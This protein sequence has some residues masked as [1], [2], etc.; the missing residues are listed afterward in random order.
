ME[1]EKSKKK[2][3]I[4]SAINLR[5]GG[6]LSI[7]HDCL[8]YLD[9]ALTNSYKVVALIHSNS[10]APKT[11]NIHYI[12]FPK[13]ASC[14]LFR[15]YYEY[16]YFYRLSKDLNPYVWLSLHDTSPR[17]NT[18]IQAVYCH[19][20]SPFYKITKKDFFLDK[21]FALQSLLYKFIYLINIKKNNYVIVQQ[22]WIKK[23]F[24]KAFK[25][26]NIIVAKPDTNLPVLN[27][28]QKNRNDKK[29][30]FYPSF[31]RVFKNFE[32]I[33]KAVTQIDEKYKNLFEVYL[34]IN[35]NEN[36]Y[37][38][39]LYKKYQNVKNIKFIGFQSREK[40]FKIYA[41]SDCLIFPSKLETWGLPITEYKLFNKPILVSDLKYAHETIGDY[42]KVKF[43][44]P[45]NSQMLA[46]YI[47][48]FLEKKLDFL[49]HSSKN[50]SGLR[51]SSWSE[52]FD[53]LLNRN[54]TK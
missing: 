42:N 51:S 31:P 44:N 28:I 23:E 12:E 10:I 32:V 36:K 16:F 41:K 52:L 46:K 14:Y 2:L 3:I 54:I 33:C 4:I 37:S 22:N 40:V 26:K 30:F 24:K 53:I 1:I 35:G 20:P 13:S 8:N 43:F 45:N 48:D 50:Q 18:I 11:K 49:K 39:M 5:S 25:L 15:L 19:N 34:T 6:P 47:V 21:N 29:I 38:Q 17:V 27:N 9:F 7:L